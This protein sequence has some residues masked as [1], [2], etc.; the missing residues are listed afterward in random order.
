LHTTLI[1]ADKFDFAGWQTS[2]QNVNL[3]TVSPRCDRYGS[4]L[5]CGVGRIPVGWN[6]VL[7]SSEAVFRKVLCIFCLTRV[8]LAHFVFNYLWQL[9]SYQQLVIYESFS[10]KLCF[11]FHSLLSV[12]EFSFSFM[13]R[14]DKWFCLGMDTYQN[15]L[16]S[17]K[18][19]HLPP[20]RTCG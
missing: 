5:V 4:T 17:I 20:V 8:L 13:L 12:R 14:Q 10:R 2:S 16:L 1:V 3:Q 9:D 11:S 15:F 7:V 18:A 19:N 6:L